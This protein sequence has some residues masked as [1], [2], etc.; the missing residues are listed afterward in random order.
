MF[1]FIANSTP[2]SNFT[3]YTSKMNLYSYKSYNFENNNT[4]YVSVLETKYNIKKTS[5]ISK[6]I[7][8]FSENISTEIRCKNRER[9]TGNKKKLCFG[10]S[11]LFLN[12]I[13][14]KHYFTR[15][16]I[17]PLISGISIKI[18]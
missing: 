6:F 1:C 7:H 9:A 15:F 17:K 13:A 8:I 12:L 4:F 14:L 3:W 5:M 2:Y 10:N 16:N 18:F 11:F